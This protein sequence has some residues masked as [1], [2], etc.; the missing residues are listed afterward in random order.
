MGAP[1]PHT[2]RSSLLTKKEDG[3]PHHCCIRTQNAAF[4]SLPTPGFNTSRENQLGT[5]RFHTWMGH[6][7]NLK[8]EGFFALPPYALFLIV[9]NVVL[10]VAL[11]SF[12]MSSFAAA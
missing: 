11:T 5:N 4:L 3:F 8:K 9:S 1:P 6:R 7:F 2:A 10:S 12:V